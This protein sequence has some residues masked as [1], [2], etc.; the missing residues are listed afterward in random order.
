M[1]HVGGLSIFNLIVKMNPGSLDG[2]YTRQPHLFPLSQFWR[3][4]LPFSVNFISSGLQYLPLH[5]PEGL[6][7]R[8]HPFSGYLEGSLSPW[9]DP[10]WSLPRFTVIRSQAEEGFQ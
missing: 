3:S 5:S 8:A 1:A 9:F 6:F 7:L 2:A 10:S 4:C